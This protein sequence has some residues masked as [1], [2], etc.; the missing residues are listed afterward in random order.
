VSQLFSFRSDRLTF[1]LLL[2]VYLLPA[3]EVF[4]VEKEMGSGRIG[5]FDA[6]TSFFTGLLCFYS[7]KVD[8]KIDGQWLPKS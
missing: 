4:C 7:E 3:C 8:I 5:Y 1:W 2:P 6:D